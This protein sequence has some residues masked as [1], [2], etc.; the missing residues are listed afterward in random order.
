MRPRWLVFAMGLPTEDVLFVHY[1]VPTIIMSRS[2]DQSG[3]V[4][5]SVCLITHYLV[6]MTKDV[7]F[8]YD[9]V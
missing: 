2:C 7:L 5:H 8:M 9:M 6:L 3:K 4:T 1:M